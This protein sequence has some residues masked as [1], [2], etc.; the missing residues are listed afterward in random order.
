MQGNARRLLERR[1]DGSHRLGK[2]SKMGLAPF[3]LFVIVVMLAL[4]VHSVILGSELPRLNVGL[5]LLA[6][7]GVF[8]TSGGLVMFYRCNRKDPGYIKV[9]MR[10]AQNMKDDEP[11]LKVEIENP[12]LVA[13][14]WSQLCITCK[15]VRPLR[16]K[17]CSICDRCV[18]QFDHHCPWVSNCIGKK[19]KRDFLLFLLMEVA[20][21]LI[22]GFVALTSMYII[23]IESLHVYFGSGVFTIIINIGDFLVV[24]FC[25]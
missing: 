15:I 6:W 12:A 4:Y 1:F 24:V 20:A 10:D 3:L 21:M 14:N 5:G 16:A 25:E 7:L 19:N 11:L 22:T 23:L 13:G 17:H 8:L 9:S 2:F 18:E